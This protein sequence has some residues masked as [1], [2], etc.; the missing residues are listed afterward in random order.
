MESVASTSRR[1][2]GNNAKS[3]PRLTRKLFKTC[4]NTAKTVAAGIIRQPIRKR[5]KAQVRQ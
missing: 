2:S 4:G 5:E 3:E 1:K